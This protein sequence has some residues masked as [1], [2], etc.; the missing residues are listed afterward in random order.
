MIDGAAVTHL[1]VGLIGAMV[2]CTTVVTIG[3]LC[4]MGRT[5]YRKD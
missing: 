5:A 2:V 3:A 1:L 4:A